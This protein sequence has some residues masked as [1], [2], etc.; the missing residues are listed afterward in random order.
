MTLFDFF[1][2]AEKIE[3]PGRFSDFF[4]H[5]PENKKEE[6]LKEAARRANEE[7]RE[8]FERSRWKAKTG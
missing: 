7:Q 8:V 2:K 4:L 5:A 3:K 6:I 1:R